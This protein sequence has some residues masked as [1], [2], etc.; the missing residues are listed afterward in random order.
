MTTFLALYRGAS[1]STAELVAVSA[2]QE[3]VSDFARQLVTEGPGSGE[4]RGLHLIDNAES[5]KRK[6]PLAGGA[7]RDI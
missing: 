1:I 6:A 7:D 2:N 4:G 5:G 3:I